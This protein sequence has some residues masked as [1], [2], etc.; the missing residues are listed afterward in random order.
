LRIAN[1]DPEGEVA[2]SLLREAAA[3]VRPLYSDGTPGAPAPRNAPLRPRDIYVAAFL[4][5][6]AVACGSLRERD[7][8]DGEIRRMYVRRDY[9]RR[10]VGHALLM[11]LMSEARR[12]GYE[13]LC[14]E[15]GTQQPAAMALY[16][17]VGFTRM[18]PFGE[19][20][21]DPTSVCYEIGLSRIASRDPAG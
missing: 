21:N 11:H 1:I 2:L 4:N 16:E 20:M 8:R 3:E 10:R 7:A 6:V 9:R 15:T 12:L 13:R 5:E 17:A 19:Y 18:A 14:L